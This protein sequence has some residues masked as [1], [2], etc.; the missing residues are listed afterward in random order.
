MQ[1]VVHETGVLVGAA[2]FVSDGG[3]SHA[4]SLH[5]GLEVNH[6]GIGEA[7]TLAIVDDGAVAF[8]LLAL[9]GHG[10]HGDATA[11]PGEHG[12]DE[13]GTAFVEVFLGNLPDELHYHFVVHGLH[14]R[15]VGLV[16]HIVAGGF[17]FFQSAAAAQQHRNEHEDKKSS[18]HLNI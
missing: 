2:G 16:A 7:A 14:R 4:T 11:V 12:L 9:Q 10:L 1:D 17:H 15:G 3:E 8:H 13:Y 5:A 6:V 18:S